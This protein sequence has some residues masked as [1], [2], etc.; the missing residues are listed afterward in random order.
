VQ[1][2]YAGGGWHY[3]VIDGCGHVK[4]GSPVA[5]LAEGAARQATSAARAVM[6]FCTAVDGDEHGLRQE[7]NAPT[8]PDEG[9]SV[10]VTV[11]GS[12]SPVF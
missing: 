11:H 10:Q 2:L 6:A 7:S 12:N 3:G 8:P 4:I 5:S 1:V 9:I